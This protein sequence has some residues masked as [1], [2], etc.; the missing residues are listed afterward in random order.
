M[1]R[2]WL[3]VLMRY[4]VAVVAIILATL[5]RKLLDPALG[6][7]S[8]FSAYFLALM[9]TAWYGGLRPTLLAVALGALAADYF[10][11][12]PRGS[13]FFSDWVPYDREHQVAVVLYGLTGVVMGGLF[14]SLHR[15]R[16]RIEAARAELADANRG[17]QKEIAERQQAEQW[18]LE[19]EHRFRGY[20]EQGLV[21]MAMLSEQKELVEVNQRFCRMLGYTEE[22]LPGRTWDKL[23]FPD[24]WPAEDAQFQRMLRGVV[25]GYFRDTRF[26]CKDGKIVYASL[27]AQCMRKEDGTLDCILVLV[28]DI[29]DR[30]RLEDDL[31]AAKDSA[32]KAK[33]VAELANRS[34]D[35]FLAVLSH[36]LRTPLAPVVMGISILQDKPDLDPQ[37]RETLDVIRR[38]AEMEARLIDD[39]LDLTRVAR[40]KIELQKERTSLDKV[41][42]YA[43][44]VCRPDIVARGLVFGMDMGPDAPYWLEADLT[45]LQQVFWNLL[46]NAVKFTPHG[47]C[48]GVRCRLDGPGHVV[49]EVRDNG[50]GIEPETIPRLF[51]AFEQA[52]RS[53][54]RQFGGL[55]LGLAISKAMV[56]MHG[57]SIEAESEGRGKGATFRVRL[58]LAAPA[59]QGESPPA[60]T[61]AK[62]AIGPLRILLVEDHAVTA[63][64]MCQ[65]LA[66]GGHQVEMAGDVATALE[67][68]GRL[69]FDLLISDLGLPDISGHDLVRELR[70]RDC[71][72]P[73]VALSG[74][75]QEEDVLRSRDAGFAAHLTKPVSRERLIETIASVMIMG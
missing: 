2:R 48:I 15:S 60:A 5:L 16:R 65:V 52:E 24:D 10:F 45:R 68:A 53:I 46:K 69:P 17:L 73:A 37:T 20:F 44:D 34:K 54:N 26:G 36:E 9:V 27:A 51:L 39:L 75:G 21:G 42:G 33:A 29:T 41:L 1:S 14:E 35:Y 49:V 19:S 7:A 62:P 8:P 25:K 47:G 57:G 23:I 40:G 72:F 56:E 66:A 38:N 71:Q 58:P 43:V 67:L 55:G 30:K 13:I 70:S 4:G 50:I 74:Y 59:G 31:R 6:D 12:T 3:S 18:L 32:E 64:M 22:E 11:I 28:Q 63:K 61:P